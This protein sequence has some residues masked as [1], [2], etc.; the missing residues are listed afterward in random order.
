MLLF[1]PVTGWNDTI[2]VGPTHI[3]SEHVAGIRRTLP[4]SLGFLVATLPLLYLFRHFDVMP[5]WTATLAAGA[6]GTLARVLVDNRWTWRNQ[7]PIWSW[8]AQDYAAAAGAFVARWVATNA[9][10]NLG[11]EYVIA[12]I[13]AAG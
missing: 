13:A 1:G 4:G 12:C 9:L 11:L 3:P 2:D 8:L 6:I 5:I 7:Y 10:N